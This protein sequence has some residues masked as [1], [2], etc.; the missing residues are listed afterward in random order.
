MEIM[1]NT[2]TIIGL[3]LSLILVSCGGQENN[4]RESGELAVVD[5]LDA[6]TR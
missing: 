1:R 2:M 4:H 3:A 5:S 6:A